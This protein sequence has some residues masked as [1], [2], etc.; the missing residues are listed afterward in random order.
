MFTFRLRYFLLAVA[1]FITEVIIALYVH[2]SFIR[3]HFGDYLVVIFIYCFVRGFTSFRVVPTALGVL[4]FSFLIEFLQYLSFVK[5]L[6][7]EKSRIASVV[8]GTAF[9][10]SDIAAYILG[11]ATVLLVERSR[12]GKLVD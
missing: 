3:P 8:L 5:V 10:W 6:G 4:L 2:D 1:L 7:L 12:P 11:I 9:E